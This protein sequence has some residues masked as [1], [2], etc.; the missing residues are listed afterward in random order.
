MGRL[1]RFDGQGGTMM[2]RH[3]AGFIPLIIDEPREFPINECRVMP[4]MSTGRPIVRISVVGF[5]PVEE[6]MEYD[7]KKTIPAGEMKH[8]RLDISLF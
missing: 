6:R 3:T 1:C 4:S 5:D 8:R 7:G 2:E